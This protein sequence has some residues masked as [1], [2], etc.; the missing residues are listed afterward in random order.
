MHDAVQEQGRILYFNVLGDTILRLRSLL[1][2]KEQ[3][4]AYRSRQRRI[5]RLVHFRTAADAK[6]DAQMVWRASAEGRP[7]ELQKR[8]RLGILAGGVD[9]MSLASGVEMNAVMAAESNQHIECAQMLRRA[10][11]VEANRRKIYFG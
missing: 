9:R 8:L 10:V 4:I 2:N 7:M 1:A 5:R 3:H 6:R 11:S